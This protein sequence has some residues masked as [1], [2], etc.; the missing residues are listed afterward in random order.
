MRFG[1]T[2]P[3]A[4]EPRKNSQRAVQLSGRLRLPSSCTAEKS[5]S[6]KLPRNSHYDWY[7]ERG[8]VSPTIKRRKSMQ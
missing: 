3:W 1:P 6:K 4:I 2:A 8:Q 7:R 5:K